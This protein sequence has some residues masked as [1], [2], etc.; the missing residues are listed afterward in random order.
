MDPFRVLP[1]LFL[2][3]ASAAL[4]AD[5]APVA[6]RATADYVPP[7]LAQLTKPASSEL[8]ELVER[9]TTDRAELERFYSVKYS[10]LHLRRMREFYSAWQQ[11][12]GQVAFD[13][14]GAEGRIDHTLLRTHLTYELR[15]LDREEARTR[16]IA[17]LLPFAEEVAQLQ[18]SRRLM[19]PVEPKAAAA[20]LDRMCKELEQARAGLEAGLKTEKEKGGGAKTEP[21][22]DPAPAETKAAPIM[23]TRIAAYRAANRLAELRKSLDDWFKHFD[24]YDPLFGWW[25]RAPYKAL[26]DGL[27]GYAKFLREKVVGVE[28]GKDEP[29]IG[30]PIGRD[31]LMAELEHEMIAYTPEQLIDIANREFAWCD[32]EWK[33]AAREMGC[34]DDWKAAL[35]K[36]KQDYV[37][38]GRQPEL[39][40]DL[41]LE[42][43]KFVSDR[44]LVTIPP[45]AADMWRLRILSPAEQKVSPFFLGGN[46]IF[47]SYPT[48]TMEEDQKVQSLRANNIHFARATVFHELLP[49]HHLQ[50]YY[51][52]RVNQHREL[53]T[54]PFWIEGWALW[55]EFQLWDQGFPRSPQDRIGMLFWRTHRCARIIF[56]LNFHL[57]KWTPQQCIDFLVDRVGHERAS[58]TGEVRR[59]FNGDYSPLYQVGYM[60]G[61]LQLRELHRELVT[62][63]RMTDLQFHDGIMA[64][65]C[66]SIEMVRAHLK[67]EKLPPDFKAG[68]RF[69]D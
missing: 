18:E 45:L 9:F 38:P 53:F 46:D 3:A 30:D 68:W 36:V 51:L 12:L 66:M 55:W 52:A 69:A 24:G 19:Q 58:A 56:S 7:E 5:P 14:L 50:F 54:T 47:V 34:G 61:A 28:P 8:R 27:D 11:R 65:G 40:R 37:E 16:E 60:M 26:N 32:A 67:Q 13:T 29:I 39:V 42:A 59:S 43:I 44:K 62:A 4:A 63:G 35:E 49:G 15:L 31:G 17:P 10:A 22:K 25:T 41:A 6:T 1:A 33:R 48:D 21:G 64:G 2:V 20:S 57:G 23:A